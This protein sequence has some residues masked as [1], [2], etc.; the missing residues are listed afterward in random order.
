MSNIA[1][2]TRHGGRNKRFSTSIKKVDDNKRKAV[3]EEKL[4]YLE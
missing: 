1:Q 4:N 3:I 2:K